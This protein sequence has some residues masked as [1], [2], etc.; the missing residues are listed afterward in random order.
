MAN[1]H[2]H[3]TMT[4]SSSRSS[5]RSVLATVVSGAVLGG[6]WGAAF[7]L[8]ASENRPSLSVVGHKGAQLI[9]IDSSEARALVM[10]GEPDDLLMDSLPAMM[11]LFRQRI[12]LLVAAQP[13]LVRH[14]RRLQNRWAIRHALALE[15]HPALDVPPVPTTS[16]SD[17]VSVSLG[18]SIT[19]Q[20]EVAHRND[21]DARVAPTD[22]ILWTASLRHPGGQT[23]IASDM[24]S[25]DASSHRS[26]TLL[27]SPE[28]PLDGAARNF[29]ALAC[30]YDSEAFEDAAVESLL[31]TRLYP[32]DI[33]RFVLHDSGIDL[34]PWTFQP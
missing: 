31:V 19:L 17:V 24:H 34:P 18:R 13:V 7:P 12:D 6:I 22:Q 29:G 2:H 4:E 14:A 20:C 28:I 16:V 21:W 11:T 8:V 5:R 15:S 27:I 10:V 9:L 33:A 3:V 30:N 25:L 23:V 32:E 1:A 26:G